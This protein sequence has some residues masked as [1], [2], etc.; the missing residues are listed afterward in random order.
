M[1]KLLSVVLILA[2]LL[3][4]A[5]F[6][7]DSAVVGC[8]A[9]YEM[10]TDGTPS[11]AMLYLAEDHTCYFLIQAFHHD[12]AGLGRTHVGTWKIQSDGSIYAKT[13][14]N[15]DMELTLYNEN[16]AIKKDTLDIY[17]NITPF[18]LK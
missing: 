3:P 14:N 4:F 5:A 12:E 1:K 10:Q 17:V 9:H 6:A 7:D 18:S 2:I 13:G 8:W 15:T 16:F 11:M